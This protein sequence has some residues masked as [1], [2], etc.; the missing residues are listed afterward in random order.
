MVRVLIYLIGIILSYMAG[1]YCLAKISKRNKWPVDT[2][3]KLGNFVL[4][5]VSWGGL[6]IWIII[7]FTKKLYKHDSL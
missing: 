6:L 2:I 3:M 4:A 5:Y 1:V 7:Y